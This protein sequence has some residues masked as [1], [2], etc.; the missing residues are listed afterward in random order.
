MLETSEDLSPVS[1][2]PLGTDPSVIRFDQLNLERAKFISQN[3]S[4]LGENQVTADSE[5]HGSDPR[6]VQDVPQ[7][8]LQQG[9]VNEAPDFQLE[10]VEFDFLGAGVS[11]SPAGLFGSRYPDRVRNTV[12]QNEANSVEIFSGYVQVQKDTLI[13]EPKYVATSENIAD[14]FTKVLSKVTFAK[15]RAMAGIK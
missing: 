3:D 1:L 2:A 4:D 5:S 13:I 11:H 8:V 10:P 7:V 12:L 6:P 15:L 9:I 14:F